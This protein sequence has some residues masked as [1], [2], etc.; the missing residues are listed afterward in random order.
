MVLCRQADH[1]EKIS[2]FV[3]FTID[4]GNMYT[5]IELHEILTRLISLPG[6]TE[7]VE[8]K[9]AE[10]GFGDKELGQYFS[11]LSNESNLKAL[12]CGW[13]V[14]G[15][16][17]KTHAIIGSNYKRT[18]VSLDS[19][20]KRIA[21]QTT[22]RITFEEIYTLKV[23][24]K[25]VVMFQIPAAPRGMP[26]AYQGIF[27][28]RDSE[29]LVP[30]NIQEIEKIRNQGKRVDWS[31]SIVAGA[32]LQDLDPEA[33]KIA[34]K[35]FL[36]KHPNLA[37]DLDSW[38][39]ATFLDKAKITLKGRITNAAIVLLGKEESEALISPAVAKIKWILKDH[40]GVERDYEIFS[41]PMLLAVEAAARKIRNLKYRY[42]N[43]EL[44]TIFP[45]EIDT[46]EPY[47][48]REA[49][50]N[51]V[52]H[53]DYTLGG[54][55]NLVEYD[56]KVVFSNKGE[57]I[58]GTIENVLKSD[59]PEEVYRN[60]FLANAMVNLKMVDTIG[61]GIKK[62][63]IKQRERLFP[64]PVYELSS[65][66]V[67][68]TI[69][70]KIFD[71]NYSNILARNKQLSLFDI[72]YLNQIQF[73]KK[74][75]AAIVSYLRGKGLIEGR[76]P[77]IFISKS[78]AA[79]TGQKAEYSKHKGMKEEKCVSFLLDALEDHEQMSKAD[80]VT[81]LWDILPDILTDKQKTCK[82][83]NLLKKMKKDGLIDVTGR[84]RYPKWFRVISK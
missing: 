34:R 7:V 54:Q 30:L 1:W 4:T 81:L 21:D 55:I 48:I 63:Y 58:P 18:R 83:D 29:S 31:R 25:R 22:N 28:G 46:Y 41:C 26:I 57:F 6:E 59:S 61:S 72:E 69:Y 8:F 52:A 66:R 71:I 3:H 39:D 64:L 36:E 15:I 12:E 56:D 24:R 67:V 43:P 49:L 84:G 73:G 16:E 20:K 80:I 9:K 77:N 74:P 35:K 65:N 60:D 47:V 40:N 68:V 38:S 45:E 14:F 19:M 13:L 51:A 50:N 5:N 82:V 62:M 78:I 11:A 27:Y 42:I 2:I 33:I 76:M 17:N 70:G 53:Q 37:A 32:T 23:D 44:M 79:S 75:S 10:N